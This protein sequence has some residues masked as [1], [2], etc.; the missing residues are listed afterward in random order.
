M[1]IGWVNNLH[2]GT[3]ILNLKWLNI[4]RAS[5]ICNEVEFKW[6]LLFVGKSQVCNGFVFRHI[7]AEFSQFWEKISTIFLLIFGAICWIKFCLSGMTSTVCTWH[8]IRQRIL[9]IW[10]RNSIRGV[11]KKPMP[12]GRYYQCFDFCNNWVHI[13]IKFYVMNF[14]HLK[15]QSIRNN[16]FPSEAKPWRWPEARVL[17]P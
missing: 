9:N 11:K 13:T 6:V 12:C 4:W 15:S 1:R 14:S 17:L 2:L 8:G 3:K 16:I 5:F 10:A 7:W